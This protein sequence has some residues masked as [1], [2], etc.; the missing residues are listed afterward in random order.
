MI[1]A[2]LKIQLIV[3][4][5][6]QEPYLETQTYFSL[7]ER[8]LVT[9]ATKPNLLCAVNNILQDSNI[10]NMLSGAPKNHTSMLRNNKSFFQDY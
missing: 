10:L 3:H 4:M 2:D 7:I 8:I 9:Y 6:Y 1:I 5:H